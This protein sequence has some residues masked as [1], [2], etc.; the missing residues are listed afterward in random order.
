M[1]TK[2][3]VR[4]DMENKL[5]KLLKLIHKLPEERLDEVT[6]NVEE[7]LKKES[8]TEP[9]P[10]CP[11]CGLGKVLRSGVRNNVQ[12]YK[13]KACGKVFSGRHNSVTWH[14]H[15]GEA[16]WKQLI[17]DTVEGKP[18]DTTAS[19]LYLTH[20]TTFNM[21][22]KVLLALESMSEREPAILEGVC[23]LDETY[24][25][26]SYKGTK[27]PEDFWR[28][29]R[30]HGARAQKRGISNEQIAI[31]TGLDRAG[32]VLAR[33]VN[34][35]TPSALELS[36]VFGEHIGEGSLVLTD[37]AQSYNVLEELCKVDIANVNTEENKERHFLHINSANAFH[38]F[39]KERYDG[40]RG[41]AT[42][43]LNRYNTLFSR[44]FR[45]GS[46][47]ADEI[48]NA[49]CSNK[50]NSFHSIEEVKS[51]NLLPL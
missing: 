29:S 50:T 47:L 5:S 28:K 27:L 7:I 21:R 48:Y 9:L 35:A 49:L 17:R 44:I 6:A 43:Y 26:E 15:S 4:C 11:K 40:Y 23:E 18:L 41:V 2:V 36:E 42:K 8:G 30:K 31:C 1:K 33:T 39:I 37:G 24:V 10:E 14:S 45:N 46:D 38:S 22:H 25:L 34:R 16:V 3:R 19:E 12:R 32:N 13:C 51:Y 20:T